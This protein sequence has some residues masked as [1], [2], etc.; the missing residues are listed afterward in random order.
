MRPSDP[1]R[2]R[3]STAAD[4][5]PRRTGPPGGA[6]GRFRRKAAPTPGL[7][8]RPAAGSASGPGPLRRPAAVP[9]VV[10]PA[11]LLAL[12]PQPGPAAPSSHA[13]PSSMPSA[14]PPAATPRAPAAATGTTVVP[15]AVRDTPPDPDVLLEHGRDRQRGF[16]RT[17]RWRV[18][19][20]FG[21]A[22][23][24]CDEV[25][26]RYCLWH[27]PD[28]PEWEPPPERPEVTEARNDL[29][30][31]LARAQ[32]ALPAGA[33]GAR[34]WVAGQRVRYLVE[35]GRGEE[36]VAAA[37][38]CGPGWWCRALEGYALHALGRH[39][40]AEAAFGWALEEMPGRTLEEWRD[41]SLLLEGEAADRYGELEGE[42]RRRFEARLWW[43]SDPLYLVP[44]NDRR[45]EHFARRTAS[46]M[47]EEASHPRGER[48]GTDLQELLLR[49]GEPAGY[50]REAPGR[51]RT[52]GRPRL[53]AHHEPDA[54]RFLPSPEALLDPFSAGPDG[55]RPLDPRPRTSYGPPYMDS[56]ADLEHRVAVFR[57]GDSARVVAAYR[58]DV[59]DG[60]AEGRGE[61]EALLRLDRGPG[62]GSAS[63]AGAAGAAAGTYAPDAG[64]GRRAD[65]A[66]A[67]SS[68]VRGTAAT[69]AGDGPAG[70]LTVAV[71][72]RPHLLALEVLDREGRMGWRARHGLRLSPHPEGVPGLSSLLLLRPEGAPAASLAGAVPR[73]RPPGAFVPGEAV[74]LF[75][76]LYG[77][78]LL[79]QEARVSVTLRGGGGW[80]HRVAGA[81]GLGG[82]E[83]K[84]GVEWRGGVAAEG[85]IHSGGLLFRLP[86]GLEAGD[87][88]LELSVRVP[89]FDPLVS[90]RE[91]QVEEE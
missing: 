86:R 73:V 18:P 66:R 88:R 25:V 72:A 87:Y 2:S 41:V 80:L 8:G 11:I 61:V 59:G 85:R 50:E 40:E 42:D 82:E 51:L 76:E 75:W 62:P 74:G 83:E 64:A 45:S 55:W 57:R 12:L 36:A 77:P 26:G 43:L 71:P 52:R 58:A 21:S 1:S 89:G 39:P 63:E 17:R 48:W 6:P 15:P 4:G 20:R 78:R 47:R 29:L 28:G 13:P 60:E 33:S 67:G 56:V 53:V 30:E 24:Q 9:V 7:S 3:S 14:A 68:V 44:G 37:R 23:G 91:I 16:E 84:A 27:D 46:R 54:R 5:T 81:L 22:G 31:M 10:A 35:A 79:L 49:Y 38:T 65:V 34:G 90:E 70:A 32:E 19:I 69:H